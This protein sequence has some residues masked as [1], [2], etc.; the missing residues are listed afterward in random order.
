MM[1]TTLTGADT[2]R[3]KHLPLRTTVPA[4]ANHSGRGRITRAT[5][6]GVFSVLRHGAVDIDA[7]PGM[8]VRVHAGGVRVPHHAEQCSVG[9]GAGEQLVVERADRL[10]LLADAGAQIELLWPQSQQ[11]AAVH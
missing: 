10:T 9:L 6:A 7:E 2:A 8:I 11:P 1:N 4:I 5:T 3:A